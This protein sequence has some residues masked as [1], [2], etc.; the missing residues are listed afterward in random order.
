MQIVYN[1]DLVIQIYF[2]FPVCYAKAIYDY[3]ACED[4]ELTF[5]EGEIILVTSKIVDDDDGWWEGILN[6]KRGVFPSIVVE[7]MKTNDDINV[8]ADNR[9]RLNTSVDHSATF[10]RATDDMRRVRSMEFEGAFSQ[11]W[12][13]E[14]VF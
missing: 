3:E 6:G 8:F 14:P 13:D 9:P 5:D 12:Q 4:E 2:L 11:S 1:L 7:E 10:P